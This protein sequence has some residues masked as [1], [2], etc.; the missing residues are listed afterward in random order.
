MEMRRTLPGAC[1][2]ARLLSDSMNPW[3]KRR[4]DVLHGIGGFAWCEYYF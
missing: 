3:E 4:W 2:M 1:S